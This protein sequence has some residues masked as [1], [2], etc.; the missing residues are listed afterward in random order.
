V[1]WIGNN[2]Q[3]DISAWYQTS[4]LPYLQAGGNLL[5][6]T[7]RGQDFIDEDMRDYL[8][9]TW[10]ENTTNT[11]VN[12]IAD[13]PGLLSLGFTDVQSII[14]VFGTE[15]TGEESRLLFKE[16]SSFSEERALGVW[17]KPVSG[18]TYRPQGGQFVFISGRPYRYTLNE[19]RHNSEFILENFFQE[20]KTLDFDKLMKGKTPKFYALHQNY[21]N[22]FNPMTA[23]GYQLPAVSDVELSIYNLLGQ[24]IAILVSKRQDTGEYIVEWNASELSNGIYYYRLKTREF[25][26][27]KKMILLK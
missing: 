9:I 12:C 19:L 11:I 22:P 10:A 5:L 6:M 18:G 21:P 17:K 15:F 3:G 8:G 2:Y 27:V 25:Q 16:T 7:R 4:I 14:A 13:Y 24:K 20:S 26:D 23:I 1:I